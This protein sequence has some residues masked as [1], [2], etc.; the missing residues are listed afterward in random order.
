MPLDHP[1]DWLFEEE[2]D[3]LPRE[4]ISK[5][6]K[7][8]ARMASTYESPGW[9]YQKFKNAFGEFGSSSS[10]DW[11]SYDFDCAL[12]AH[13]KNGPLTIVKFWDA[14]EAMRAD[15]DRGI[16]A[17]ST[18]AL[19]QQ[20]N[21]AFES[22]N[23]PYFINLT[24][25]SLARISGLIVTRS[26]PNSNFSTTYKKGKM[27]GSGGFGEVY[28][29]TRSTDVGEFQFAIKFLSPSSLASVSE[30]GVKAHDR[31]SREVMAAQSLTHR[32]IIRYVDAGKTQTGTP[33]LVMELI[34]GE[35]IQ[36]TAWNHEFRT[37]IKLMI[38][39]L[40]ALGHAHAA[41]VLHRDL[42]PSNILVRKSDLQPIIADF[43][44]AHLRDANFEQSLTS[45]P[46]GTLGYIPPEVLED[47]K[48]RDHLHDIYSCGIILYQLF[49]PVRP[50]Y[51]HYKTLA[52]VDEGLVGLDPIILKAIAPAN[53]RY[54]SAQDF[55]VCLVR[56]E[57]AMAAPAQSLPSFFPR[58]SSLETASVAICPTPGCDLGS[59]SP[60]LYFRGPAILLVP[61]CSHCK[62]CGAE[63]ISSCRNCGSPLAD[64][65]GDYVVTKTKSGS[66]NTKAS[67]GKCGQTIYTTPTCKTCHSFLRKVDLVD[68]D[69]EDCSKCRATRRRATRSP[70]GGNSSAGDDIEF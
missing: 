24:D 63:L 20:F 10:M 12:D 48:R 40:D 16:R 30:Q 55:Q 1:Q 29:A 69:T 34:D 64:D 36:K 35:D 9:I 65:I 6:K 43:G 7:I 19:S 11:A 23:Y 39:V 22:S 18:E 2:L 25:E 33:F 21:S 27:L 17:P 67:C 66:D 28:I 60:N 15:P 45:S 54:Q 3:P 47:P 59:W 68:P 51:N 52:E 5:I 57:E 46:P 37:R 53:D 70:Y 42:K 4:V 8:V 32:G 31:F 13:S 50:T 26:E 44:M 62:S 41:G 61:N 58:S 14:I 38:D 49:C 56:I